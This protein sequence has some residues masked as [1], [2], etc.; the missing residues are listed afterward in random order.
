MNS[1][2]CKEWK[3]RKEKMWGKKDKTKEGSQNR[4]NKC[5]TREGQRRRLQKMKGSEVDV[6]L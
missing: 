6:R 5:M 2:H 1:L 3:G 4:I